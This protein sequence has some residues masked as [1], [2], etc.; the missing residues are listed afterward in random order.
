MLHI[1]VYTRECVPAMGVMWETWPEVCH[2][3]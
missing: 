2:P 1:H 3:E